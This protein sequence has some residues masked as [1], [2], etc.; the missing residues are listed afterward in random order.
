MTTEYRKMGREFI[1][2]VLDILFFLLCISLIVLLPIQYFT[3]IDDCDRSWNDRCNMQVLTDNKTGQ[4]YL[5][6]R[7]GGIIERKEK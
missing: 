5:V 2:G 1:K 7:Q 6:T 4:E 3:P